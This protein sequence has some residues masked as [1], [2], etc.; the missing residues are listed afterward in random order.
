MIKLLENLPDTVVGIEATGEV[1]A[2]DY[3]LTIR[4]AIQRQ[5]EK[6]GKIRLLYVLG[7]EYEG[8]TAGG[9][10][11]DEK[12]FDKHLFSWEKIAI[13]TDSTS[14]RLAMKVFGWMVPGDLRLFD[15]D[16]IDQA[17]EWVTN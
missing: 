10:W 13:A 4:P 11:S 9:L 16:E 5:R 8:Y 6:Y 17:T 2:E 3:N 7:D 12:L 14:I 1:T 15:A